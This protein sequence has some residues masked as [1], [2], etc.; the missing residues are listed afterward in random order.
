MYLLS[1][2][3]TLLYNRCASTAETQKAF[4]AKVKKKC[5]QNIQKAKDDNEI[6]NAILKARTDK[7]DN[8]SEK[9]PA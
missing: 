5:S 9:P 2:I 4:T 3:R 6:K 8:K 1:K 7:V